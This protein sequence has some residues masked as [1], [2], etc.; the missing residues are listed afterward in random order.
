M[1]RSMMDSASHTPL[2]A[3]SSKSGK[4]EF[5]EVGDLAANS[6]LVTE[7]QPSRALLDRAAEVGA[8]VVVAGEAASD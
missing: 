5:A 7:R 8:T 6:T 1:M 2:L 4:R 3:D